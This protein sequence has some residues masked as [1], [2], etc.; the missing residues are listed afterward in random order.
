[1]FFE[2]VVLAVKSGCPISLLNCK[3]FPQVSA[4][5]MLAEHIRVSTVAH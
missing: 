1:M 4:P 5:G 3:H 2:N